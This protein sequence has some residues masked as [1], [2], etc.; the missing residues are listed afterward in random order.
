[1]NRITFK[2]ILF[3]LLAFSARGYSQNANVQLD[4][5][6]RCYFNTD[7]YRVFPDDNGD[8]LVTGYFADSISFNN[9]TMYSK[10]LVD[11]FF[12]RFDSNLNPVWIKHAGGNNVDVCRFINTDM[13]KNIYVSGFFRGRVFM[14][15]TTINSSGGY[16]HFTAKYS[17]QGD[18][19]WI[20]QNR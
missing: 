17:E 13:N 5:I 7:Y 15:D 11:V 10:G 18:L 14:G 4:S 1:M 6:L 19:I 12:A 8:F 9:R 20:R 16:N 3:I 2:L